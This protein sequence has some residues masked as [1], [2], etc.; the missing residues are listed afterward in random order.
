MYIMVNRLTCISTSRKSHMYLPPGSHSAA[1][2]PAYHR[3]LQQPPTPIPPIKSMTLPRKTKSCIVHDPAMTTESPLFINVP[4]V[5]VRRGLCKCCK[6]EPCQITWVLLPFAI[7]WL[8]LADMQVCCSKGN[9]LGIAF[10]CRVKYQ[11]ANG[12]LD[13]SP[14]P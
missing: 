7:S 14:K 1:R 12:L 6:A 9:D 8:F 2:L 5:F 3:E 11:V 13:L 4:P 10:S